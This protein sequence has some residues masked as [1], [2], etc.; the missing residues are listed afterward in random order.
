ML[1][2][3]Q[4]DQKTPGNADLRCQ[5]R[6]L[7]AYRLLDHLHDQRLPFLQYLLYGLFAIRPATFQHIGH[8]QECSA[9]QA[10]FDKGRL[11]ARQYATDRSLVDIADQPEGT[12]A[13]DMQLL[14]DPLFR[15]RHAGFLRCYIDQNLFTHVS[16][17]R[18]LHFLKVAP[19]QK[20]AAPSHRNN[21]P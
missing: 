18:F 7:G 1:L 14:H 17:T 8:M 9:L 16:I 12:I 20:P 4:I 6:T 2:L 11:H 3:R 10:D 19:S 5:P 15:D 13:F 21:C